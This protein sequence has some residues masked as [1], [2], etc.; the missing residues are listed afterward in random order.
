M[1]RRQ[2][3]G[4]VE[5]ARVD[6][7]RKLGISR[8]TR[9]AFSGYMHTHA[10]LLVS[11]FFLLSSGCNATAPVGPGCSDLGTSAAALRV[12]AVLNAADG[13]SIGAARLASD[14]ESVCAA[15]ATDLGV[16][17][18]TPAS[19]ELAVEATCGALATEI[20]ATLRGS[21]PSGSALVL[22]VE[23]PSCS[24]EVNAAARCAGR[25]DASIEGDAEVTCEGRLTGE[26]TA[27]CTG[28]CRI[29][30]T[31]TCASECRGTCNGNCSGS[32]T[33]GCDGT[34]SVV[35]SSGN[36]VGACDG[37]CTGSCSASCTG[38]CEG[39]CVSNIEGMCSGTCAGSCT[40]EM[41]APRCEGESNVMANASCQASCDAELRADAEC[42]EPQLT[43]TSSPPADLSV[44]SLADLAGTLQRNWPRFLAATAR[45]EGTAVAGRALVNAVTELEGAVSE[46]GAQAVACLTV[47]GESSVEAVTTLSASVDVSVSVSASASVEGG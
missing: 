2:C 27:Q 25:C 38:T 44:G 30:G 41:E 3:D 24:I 47:A 31:I 11:F 4:P 20:E 14:L 8:G 1:L 34:C 12:A 23:P 36:C 13:L 40:I 18:P 37:T 35:D 28:E 43:V 32:C 29:E 39:T 46:V 6:E 22:I 21:L 9:V 26:C 19:G 5:H 42:T 15:M 7:R 10:I 45:L 17:I 33:G 16:T